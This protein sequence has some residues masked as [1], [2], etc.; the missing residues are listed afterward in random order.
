IGETLEEAFA[1][2]A[3]ALFNLMVDLT[4]I[5]PHESIE[6]SCRAENLETLFVEWLNAL[7][8]QKDALGMVFSRFEITHLRKAPEGYLLKARAGG[9]PLDPLRHDSR[10]DVKAAT[11][12]GLKCEKITEGYQVECVV[13]I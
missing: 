3:R 10:V 13:D 6:I 5:S 11:Y 2:G 4:Q 12:A 8:V 1:E 9:E 7:I